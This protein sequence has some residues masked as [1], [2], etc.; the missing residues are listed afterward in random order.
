VL[1][2]ADVL[3]LKKYCTLFASLYGLLVP[4][5]IVTSKA[6]AY[7]TGVTY[8]ISHPLGAIEPNRTLKP[9]PKGQSEKV[10]VQV[11]KQPNE[12]SI[13]VI[14]GWIPIDTKQTPSC[15]CPWRIV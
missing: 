2:T 14:G 9:L 13:Y 11:H 15:P 6:P 8:S 3:P 5:A 12:K 7:I 4:L 1:E 10:Q